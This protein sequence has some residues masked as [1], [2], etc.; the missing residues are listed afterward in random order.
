ME[1][2]E[3][4]EKD[5]KVFC[6][7]ANKWLVAKPEEKVRQK[8]ICIL[9][10]DYGYSLDQMA[11]EQKVN[12]S[13]RGQGKARADIVIWK[14]KKDK[15]DRKAAF[16]VVECKAENVKIRVEVT[17]RVSTMPRGHMLISLLPQTRRKQ[18]FLMLIRHFSRKNL[19]KL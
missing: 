17:I 11:Q 5:G 1:K 12:N 7:L 10:N 8:Y 9:V 13:Q 4:Q 18:S 14:S 19:R 6:P 15:D 3:Y 2:L 16:I